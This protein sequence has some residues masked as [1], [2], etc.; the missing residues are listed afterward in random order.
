MMVYFED[1]DAIK[2]MIEVYAAEISYR[3]GLQNSYTSHK[4]YGEAEDYHWILS[5]A[6][7][8]LN[9]VRPG[10]VRNKSR[11]EERIFLIKKYWGEIPKPP[12]G[13]RKIRNKVEHFDEYIEEWFSDTNGEYAHHS[14]TVGYIYRFDPSNGGVVYYLEDSVSIQQVISWV[15]EMDNLINNW[16]IQGNL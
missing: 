1:E 2:A 10:R 7:K 11:S 14:S 4:D 5:N 3:A 8:I 15:K 16:K 6:V 12:E 13:L 9:I